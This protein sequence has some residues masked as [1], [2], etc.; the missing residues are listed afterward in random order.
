MVQGVP[1][2]AVSRYRIVPITKTA[3]RQFVNEH[4]RHN[5]APFQKSIS[6][7]IGLEND[8]ELVAVGMAGI[9][10]LYG[11][12]ARA[13]KAL[14]YQRLVTYTLAE[15]SGVSLRAA[16]FREEGTIRA[17]SWQDE[18]HREL[19]PRTDVTLWGERRNAANL[20]KQR[21]ERRL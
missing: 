2:E 3:A 5:E 17:R 16:G 18:S 7:T 11:A 13:A 19:R 12:L 1:L 10:A 20:P 21:W 9:S 15:E 6:F 4:H 8:G 14:G